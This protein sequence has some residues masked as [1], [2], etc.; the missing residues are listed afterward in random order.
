MNLFFKKYIERKFS[1][2]ATAFDCS[3]KHR[4]MT[5][6]TLS[7]FNHTMFSNIALYQ[8]LHLTVA[9]LDKILIRAIALAFDLCV[10]Y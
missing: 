10:L 1:Y 5:W 6:L 3:P 8:Q 7:D 4:V 9:K 2:L